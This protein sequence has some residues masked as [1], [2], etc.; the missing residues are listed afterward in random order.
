MLTGPELAVNRVRQRVS[1]G[2]HAIPE[3]V[4]HRRY[5]R[6]LLNFEQ[7]YAPLC[8]AWTLYSNAGLQIQPVASRRGPHPVNTYDSPNWRSFQRQTRLAAAEL[9]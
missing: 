4:V 9:D 1:Q 7:R 3:D 6:S 2:G 5:W 8:D